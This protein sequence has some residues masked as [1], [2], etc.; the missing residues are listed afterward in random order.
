M[1]LARLRNTTAVHRFGIERGR[2]RNLRRAILAGV[3]GGAHGLGAEGTQGFLGWAEYRQE[4]ALRRLSAGCLALVL[5]SSHELGSVWH[6]SGPRGTG[7]RGPD[8]RAA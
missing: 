5:S 3:P 7:R 1:P 8:L 4:V 6:T 2:P